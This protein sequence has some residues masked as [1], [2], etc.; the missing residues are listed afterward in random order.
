[1]SLA[2]RQSVHCAD[3]EAWLRIAEDWGR[4]VQSCAQLADS[5][6]TALLRVYNGGK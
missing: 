3:K 5:A 1:M 6:T 2:G 4:L